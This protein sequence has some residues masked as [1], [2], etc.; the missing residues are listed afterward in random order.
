[1]Q[2]NLTTDEKSIY[3]EG[4]TCFF[5]KKKKKLSASDIVKRRPPAGG[6]SYQTE[7]LSCPRHTCAGDAKQRGIYSL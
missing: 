5:L 4:K 6:L 1:M 7:W 3:N 2:L